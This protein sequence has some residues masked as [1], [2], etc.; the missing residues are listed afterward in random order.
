ML[1]VN[2][3][4]FQKDLLDI[5]IDFVL[6]SDVWLI[7]FDKLVGDGAFCF[8]NFCWNQFCHSRFAVF[9][10]FDIEK[11]TGQFKC[12]FWTEACIGERKTKLSFSLAAVFALPKL[13]G[14]GLGNNWRWYIGSWWH[15]CSGFHQDCC[16]QVI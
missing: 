9:A 12:V 6:N 8:L 2:S 3:G 7:W 15:G 13:D 4:I 11:T 1:N 10:V 14:E 16:F 5:V